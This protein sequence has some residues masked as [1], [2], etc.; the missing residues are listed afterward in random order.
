MTALP[1]L[2]VLTTVAASYGIEAKHDSS[3]LSLFL[4]NKTMQVSAIPT[5]SLGMGKP[6]PIDHK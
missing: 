1:V 4:C 2:P 6:K 5:S 3:V